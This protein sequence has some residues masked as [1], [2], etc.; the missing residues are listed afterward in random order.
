MEKRRFSCWSC[1]LMGCGCFVLLLIFGGGFMAFQINRHSPN[2]PEFTEV[3]QDDSFETSEL[4]GLNLETVPEEA[5]PVLLRFDTAQTDIQIIPDGESGKVTID[6]DYDRAN[7][8]FTTQVVPK[9]NYSIYEIQ[10][11]PVKSSFLFTDDNQNNRLIV[12]VSREL[13]IALEGEIKMGE[14]DFDLTD[15]SIESIDLDG[16]MGELTMRSESRNTIPMKKLKVD[17]SMGSVKV[18][19]ADL[20]RPDKMDFKSSMGECRLGFKGPLEKDTPLDVKMRMGEVRITIPEMLQVDAHASVK[21]GEFLS[22]P[23]IET[24]VG[25]ILKVRGNV[26]MGEMGIYRRG[27]QFVPPPDVLDEV[28]PPEPPDLPD[29]DQ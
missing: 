23:K 3:S 5:R 22:V 15:L 8:N 24:P 9:D 1:S 4:Q 6:A 20:L 19:N 28:D 16:K 29:P 17:F 10:F 13:L 27:D 18:A 11:K 12:H 7:F 2:P 26:T 21:M 14:F 25:G